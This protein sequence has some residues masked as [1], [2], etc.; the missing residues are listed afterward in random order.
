MVKLSVN[1]YVSRRV[2][3][4]RKDVN[5]CAEKLRRKILRRLNEI[6]QAAAKV[7]VGDIN[8]QRM[9]EKDGPDKRRAEIQLA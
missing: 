6:F 3:I 1:G 9:G 8:H 7:A 2:E 4:I 5:A